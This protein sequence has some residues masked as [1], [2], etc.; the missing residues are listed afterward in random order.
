VVC[1]L[2]LAPLGGSPAGGSPAAAA[3]ATLSLAI[4][5]NHFVDGS[6]HTIRLLGV[7]HPSSEYGC[8]DG[9]GYDDGHFDNADA[10]AVASWGVNAVRI[11][12]NEDCW[13]GI[14]GQPNSNEGADPPLSQA[15]YQQEVRDYVADLNAH[16]IYAILDLH[17]T[18]PGAQVA[19]EQQPMPDQDHSPAFWTSVASTFA[20]NPAVAFDLFNE[21]YDPT[22]PRSGVDQ[23]P[24]DKVSWNCWSTGTTNGP[25]GGAPCYTS[26][27]DENQTKTSTYR[28]AGLQ[29]LLD[30]IRH[31]GATQPVLAGGLDYANDL[32]TNDKGKAWMNHAPDDPRN[33][34]AA[35]F[36]NYMGQAC[37]KA[38][39]WNHTIAP[40]AK[41]VP[42]VT[43]EFD[44]DDFDE[45][46]CHNS[47]PSTFDA[48]YMRWADSAGVSYLAWG[49]IVEPKD[50]QDADGCSAYSLIDDYTHYTPA[51]PNGVAVHDHLRALASGAKP[52]VA[53][54]AFSESTNSA[55]KSIRFTLRSA[56]TCRGSLTG[57]TAHSYGAAKHKPHKVSLGTA[58][59]ALTANRSKSIALTL[60]TAA[61]KLL[62]S[63]RSLATRISITLTSAGH[64]RTVIHRKVTLKAFK[65]HH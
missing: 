53:L 44:E 40:V 38:A 2:W 32:G 59:V 58:H 62:T 46:H 17:W 29:T 6:G 34:E 28:V 11:P 19:L 50:E 22:D 55:N 56:Q 8:V 25:D 47:T 15:G 3:K 24:N 45:P 26:A 33:Q 12:L 1:A 7:N 39:C 60:S 5:G 35:S 13:L 57:T 61:R 36:H 43:G 65:P 27:Y 52:P 49:W 14:N 64:R 30:A 63:K 54:T 51:K 31:A 23:D 18:A 21:P 48:D 10:A 41:H 16:G 37:D 4:V 9:F 20:H 42:V